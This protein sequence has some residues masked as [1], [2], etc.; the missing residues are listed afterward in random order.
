MELLLTNRNK[1]FNT[2]LLILKGVIQTMKDKKNI[3]ISILS[4]II[5]LGVGYTLGTR[6]DNDKK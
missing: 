2:L 5:I 3:I 4:G 1:P 6:N